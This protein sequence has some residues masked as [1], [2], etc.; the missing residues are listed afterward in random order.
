M[1]YQYLVD[2]ALKI[3][4]PYA[5]KILDPGKRFLYLGCNLPGI[6]TLSGRSNNGY[7]EFIAN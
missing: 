6:K 1:R 2:G 5:E 7:C 4:D 3:A